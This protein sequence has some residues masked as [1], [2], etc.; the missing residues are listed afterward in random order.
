MPH[1]LMSGFPARDAQIHIST[2][3]TGLLQP[4]PILTLGEVEL[5]MLRTGLY[6]GRWRCAIIEKSMLILWYSR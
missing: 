4:E 1:V 3:S 5:W 6:R 2:S